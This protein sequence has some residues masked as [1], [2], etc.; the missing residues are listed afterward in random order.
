MLSGDIIIEYLDILVY[1]SLSMMSISSF[2]LW[3]RVHR[4]RLDLVMNKVLSIEDG[5]DTE[6]QIFLYS[7]TLPIPVAFM[8][9][10]A[11]DS[12]ISSLVLLMLISI[13]SF[14]I[15]FI[16]W[17]EYKTIQSNVRLPVVTYKKWY[18]NLLSP[19][20]MLLI[21]IFLSILWAT[22]S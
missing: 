17:Q 18:Y 22:Q 19:I 14:V 10:L 12:M 13:T 7:L 16:P 11:K 8:Y 15:I 1:W 3:L 4:H 20:S 21:T 5:S 6:T 2:I 9:I